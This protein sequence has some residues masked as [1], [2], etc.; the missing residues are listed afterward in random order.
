MKK[1][2]PLAL[3]LISLINFAQCPTD[4]I[5]LSSQ[6]DVDNFAVNYP[7][8]TVLNNSLTIDGDTNT[9][10]NLNGLAQITSAQDLIMRNTQ[11]SNFNG[12]HNLEHLTQLILW[13]NPIIQNLEGFT[14]LESMVGIVAFVNPGLTSLS[15]IDSLVSLDELSLLNNVNLSDISQLST[16]STLSQINIAGNAISSLAGLENLQ[17]VTT[18]FSIS[19]EPITDYNELVN[20]QSIGGSLRITENSLLTDL[21][22]FINIESVQDLYLTSCTS[23]MDLAGLQNIQTISGVLRIG[24]NSELININVFSNITS[25]ANLDI[26]GNDNL[27]SLSGLE[28]LQLIEERLL[29]SDNTFLVDIEALDN[30]FST[31]IDEVVIV[32]NN[33]LAVC[34]TELICAIIDEHS[35]LK[36]IANNFDGCNSVAEVSALCNPLAVSDFT[37]NNS[38]SIYP[39]PV[40]DILQIYSSE[41][42]SIEKIAI[43]SMLGESL[44]ST[45]ENSIDVSYLSEGIY[46]IEVETN[47]GSITK[48]FIKD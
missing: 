45:P 10:T 38:I 3:F 14:A 35:V 18:D 33:N 26:Y 4:F 9:I 13:Y 34:N 42:V 47:R 21:S 1:I 46:F 25:V 8:C 29:L 36:T 22:A 37:L 16:I 5:S 24:F 32:N 40:S 2:L 39:N 19:N 6:A 20:L 27:E 44:I 48:R 23:L 30:V 7:G 11:I 43:Y 17:S 15:G 28:N 41:G 12:L 31:E